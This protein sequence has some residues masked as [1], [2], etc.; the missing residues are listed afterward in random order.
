MFVPQVDMEGFRQ[1]IRDM[2]LL[3]V[4]IAVWGLVTGVAMVKGG[5]PVSIALVM[6]FT[7]FAGS[8]QLAV[9]PLLA[10]KTPL[11]IIW[12]TSL[13]VNVRFAIFSAASRD[14]FTRF[15]FHQ[16]L[17]AAYLNGDV[18]SA[19]FLKRYGA[20]TERGTDEQI[21]YFFG[22]AAVNWVAWQASSVA[23]FLLGGLAPTN[24][25][26]ELAAVLALGA[27]LIPML[28]RFPAVSGVVVTAVLSIATVR[29][30]LHLGIVISVL[31]GVAVAVAVDT[32]K[33]SPPVP[34]IEA[35]PMFS[36]AKEV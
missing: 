20:V 19:V 30:P 35:I 11:P 14:F 28:N 12:V 5:M 23:G 21:G 8:A 13:L 26:L 36:D 25:G 7:A 17:F 33:H 32:M 24:W 34:V 29:V 10:L 9:L 22:I 3:G 4:A 15:P 2:S 16:R 31:I 27:V 6:T 18:G 1:G